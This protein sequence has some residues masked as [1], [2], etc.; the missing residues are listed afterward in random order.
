VD[1]AEI[2]AE[3]RRY[4]AAS[5]TVTTFTLSFEN[6][7][8]T[9]R[10]SNLI[11]AEAARE[12]EPVRRPAGNID[13]ASAQTAPLSPG[14]WAGLLKGF[15]VNEVK[16]AIQEDALVAGRK[17]S[18]SRHNTI[19]IAPAD[20]VGYVRLCEQVQAGEAPRPNWWTSVRK[21]SN[22]VIRPRE[23]SAAAHRRAA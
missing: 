15:P 18:G 6:A 2:I 10:D 3:A 9:P 22:A 21:G 8:D 12:T 4:G 20:M 19:L 1:L 5:V 14:D 17:G 13:L 11:P 7:I 23:G 16:R